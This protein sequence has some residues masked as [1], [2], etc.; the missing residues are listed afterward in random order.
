MGRGW[1][2]VDGQEMP[3]EAASVPATD[4]GFLLGWTVFE[5]VEVEGG[6]PVAIDANLR[7]LAHSCAAAMIPPPDDD[8][9]RREVRAVADHVGGRV[10]VRVTLTGGG[11]R[12]VIG[13]PI[14]PSRRHRPVRAIRGAHRPDPFLGGHVKHGSRGPWIVAVKR[15]G[16]DEMLLVD[17]DGRFTEGTTAAILAVIDGIVWSA[18]DDG[19]ILPSTTAAGLFERAR[20]LGIPVRRDGPPAHGPWD[21][22]YIASSTRGLAP[23][24][25]LDG[26]DLPAWD[27]VGRKLAG[28]DVN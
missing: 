2:V 7:R 28:V 15:A 25:E 1:A 26:T 3:L 11:R 14:D 6:G 20:R 19:R 24:V 21:A 23:V 10:R 9:V 18:P 22:L 13:E 4:P 5:T 17:G 8:V 16:V 27:P 12:V